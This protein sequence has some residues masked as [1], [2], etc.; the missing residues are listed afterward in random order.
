M[1][2]GR[3]QGHQSNTWLLR[4]RPWAHS[5]RQFSLETDGRVTFVLL[6]LFAEK[7]LLTWFL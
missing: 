3:Q 2:M 7:L 6:T 4:Q 5:K 1:K